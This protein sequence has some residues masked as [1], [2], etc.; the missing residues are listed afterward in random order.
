MKNALPKLYLSLFIL[1]IPLFS[2]SQDS[3]KTKAFIPKKNVIRYN[4]TPNLLGFSS[5]IFG[6]ERVVKSHQSFSINAGY[7]SIGKSGKK[8]NDD[9]KL[10]STKS[11]SGFSIAADY[12]FYLKRENKNPAPSGVYLAPYFVHYD[13]NHSVG[14]KSLDDNATSA[15]TIVDSKININSLGLE[16]GY[17]FNI[18]NRFTIDMILIG[19]SYAAY[20]VNMDVV[21]GVIPPDGEL[22]ETMEA[23]REILF[24]KYPWLETLINE[25]EVD[26]KGKKTHWGL[27]FRYV[28]QIGYRF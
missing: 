24:G 28:L 18:K 10:S 6:Y 16:L 9:Y 27:G 26:I 4:L 23:L 2:F 8:E 17:Q 11:S 1:S 20:K 7:L 22:D 13:F 12:R 14:I 25:G 15:E 19:P 5:M 3:L 21:G